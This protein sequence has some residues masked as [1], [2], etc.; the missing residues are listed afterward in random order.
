MMRFEEVKEG[1]ADKLYFSCAYCG[2]SGIIVLDK[3]RPVSGLGEPLV[4]WPRLRCS[5][6]E[7]LIDP[8]Y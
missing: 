8:T 4:G 3:K 1:V 7:G 2:N 5:L 6:C